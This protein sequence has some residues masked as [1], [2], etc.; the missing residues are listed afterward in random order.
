LEAAADK[1]ASQPE[2]LLSE[3]AQER[4]RKLRLIAAS[5]P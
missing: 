4:A 5:L 1:L 3:E 2:S